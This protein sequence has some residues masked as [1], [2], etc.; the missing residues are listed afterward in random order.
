M[1][2]MVATGKRAL[3]RVHFLSNSAVAGIIVAPVVAGESAFPMHS[4][5]VQMLKTS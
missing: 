5:T 3:A 4:T 2:T 1:Y